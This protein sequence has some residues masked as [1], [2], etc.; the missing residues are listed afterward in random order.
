MLGHSLHLVNLTSY[1]ILGD[2]LEK[3]QLVDVL[4]NNL[5]RLLL[6]LHSPADHEHAKTYSPP[7]ARLSLF[8]KY[9]DGHIQDMQLLIYE[10]TQQFIRDNA[11]FEDDPNFSGKALKKLK[12]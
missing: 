3:S 1:H 10:L 6:G 2:V 12:A 9:R 5:L 11:D 7:L 8:G 4:A